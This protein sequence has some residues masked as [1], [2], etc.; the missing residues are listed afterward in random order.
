MTCS[1]TGQK[2]EVNAADDKRDLCD[3]HRCQLPSS[4]QHFFTVH[5]LQRFSTQQST[6]IYLDHLVDL[7]LVPM[8]IVS[9]ISHHLE[10][11]VTN[12]HW[13]QW[14]SFSGKTSKLPPVNLFG[15]FICCP[16]CSPVHLKSDTQK[17]DLHT[18]ISL[19]ITNWLVLT[20]DNYSNSRI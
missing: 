7:V 13:C 19:E 1:V 16:A 2:N 11:F 10:A 15:K 8:Q 4:S 12:M 17:V 18:T 20:T 14:W 3:R 5:C 9:I 6:N